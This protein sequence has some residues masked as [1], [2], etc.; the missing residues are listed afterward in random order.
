[1]SQVYNPESAVMAEIERLAREAR[2]LRGSAGPGHSDATPLGGGIAIDVAF[3]L[4]MLAV[5]LGCNV[6]RTVPQSPYYH[7]IG[8][9]IRQT[10]MAL[11]L[12]GAMLAVHVLGLCDAR[13]AMGPFVKLFV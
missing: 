13:R 6:V 8:G 10:P 4:P 7:Y 3:A 2:H 1:M 11:G 9:V 12:L 5:V